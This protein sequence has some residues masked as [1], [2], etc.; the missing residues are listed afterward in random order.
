MSSVPL[1]ATDTHSDLIRD[2]TRSYVSLCVWR[3]AFRWSP[4]IHT[5]TWFVT[6]LILMCDMTHSYVSLCVG[7]DAFRWLQRMHTATWFVTWLMHMCDMTDPYVCLY[8]WCD[9]TDSCVWHDSFICEWV[10]IHSATCVY[11]CDVTHS[12]MSHV[13]HINAYMNDCC[14]HSAECFSTRS[15]MKWVTPELWGRV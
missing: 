6:W 3:D 7:R 14:I 13:T 2:M 9:V 10:R 1:I 15:Y 5:A 12:H 4:R 11:V 8:V